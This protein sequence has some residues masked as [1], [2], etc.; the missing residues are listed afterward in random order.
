M[1]LFADPATYQ[2]DESDHEQKARQHLSKFFH[3]KPPLEKWDSC[4]SLAL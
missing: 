4:N 1:I 2:A 3:E